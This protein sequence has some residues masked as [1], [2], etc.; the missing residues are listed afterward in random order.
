MRSPEITQKRNIFLLFFISFFE[1]E[2]FL[3]FDLLD[4]QRDFFLNNTT[5]EYIFFTAMY[6]TVGSGS[7]ELLYSLPEKCFWFLFYFSF[8][9]FFFQFR[10][11]SIKIH[12][13]DAKRS[14][15]IIYRIH[16]E[17]RLAKTQINNNFVLYESDD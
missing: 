5:T 9:F 12:S 10:C 2:A 17:S 13:R 4:A 16:N 6:A 15:N 1:F 7:D 14:T 11:T 3:T 8:A